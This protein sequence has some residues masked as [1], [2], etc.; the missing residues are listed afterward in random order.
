MDVMSTRLAVYLSMATL[1]Y[2]FMAILVL[3][4][5]LTGSFSL[6]NIIISEVWAQ[7][8]N[9]DRLVDGKKPEE[10]SEKK[11]GKIDQVHQ[12]MSR[13]ILATANWLDSFFGDELFEAEENRSRVRVRL[14]SFTED[15]EDTDL[16][17]NFNLRVALPQAENRLF[18]VISGDEDDDL[19]VDDTLKDVIGGEAEDS[20][21]TTSLKYFFKSTVKENISMRVAFLFRDQRFVSILG[22][23][24]RYLMKIDPWSVRFTQRARYQTDIGWD[25][26]T[27]IDFEKQFQNKYFF[28][29]TVKGEWF[30]EKNGFFYAIGFSLFHPLDIIRALQYEWSNAF[31]T[32]PDN[33]LDVSTLKVRY[34]QRIWRDW[35]FFEVTPQVSCPRDRDFEFVSGILFRLEAHFGQYKRLEPYPS[36][37]DRNSGT[38]SGGDP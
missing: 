21:L 1:F 26:R 6:G 15:G 12:R 8:E 35:L 38:G 2:L 13:R 14:D 29:T 28:R 4:I 11:E 5:D 36:S 23:R 24:Y 16:D 34:R 22:P 17:V 37:P 9:P 10:M 18:L 25:E 30:E 33:T 20:D 32:S 7:S 27:S 3:F 31:L 19:T